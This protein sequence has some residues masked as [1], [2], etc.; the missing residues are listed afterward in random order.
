[1]RAWLPVA[2]ALLL[3]ACGAGTASTGGST[4]KPVSTSIDLTSID[5]CS[6]VSAATASQLVG[7]TVA[8]VSHI[9]T[10]ATNSCIYASVEGSAGVAI[11]VQQTPGGDARAVVKAALDHNATPAARLTTAV[12]GIGDAAGTKTDANDAAVV[13]A[14]HNLLIVLTA[15][16]AGTSGAILLPKLE[17][18][19]KQ[20]A[21]KL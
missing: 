5:S 15:T 8:Q 7:S 2:A 12:G 10:S 14:K 20:L 16:E 19:A 18:L 6:L 17:A 11:F 1:L 13:F 21:A 4:P 9:A 3:A